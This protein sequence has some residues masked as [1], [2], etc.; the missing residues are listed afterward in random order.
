MARS[1]TGESHM[2]AR[3]SSPARAT[4]LHRAERRARER[5]LTRAAILDSARRVAAREGAAN[6]SLRAV[7][8]EAGFAPAALYGYFAGKNELL[9]ALA[10]ED[11][12]GLARAMRDAEADGGSRLGAAAGAA[13]TLLRTTETIATAPGALP[14]QA[15]SGEA[16]RHFNG[17]LIAALR[18]LS[19]AAGNPSDSRETQADVVLLAAALA[20]LA[21]FARSGRL[22][23]LGF[24]AADM[25]AALDRRFSPAR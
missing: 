22:E 4:S 21:V 14:A 23:V 5:S 10:A 25:I 11:L 24:S 6:L 9:I 19:E 12:T 7:A 16:E 17:K 20:G 15:G 13:L 3:M 8:A 2:V 18:A 1:N